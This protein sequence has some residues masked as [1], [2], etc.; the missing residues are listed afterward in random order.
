[1]NKLKLGFCM[2]GSFCTFKQNFELM[3]SLANE[4]DVLPIMSYNA[5][6]LDTRFGKAIDNIAKAE[7]I[8]RKPAIMTIEDAEPI[9]P[10]NLTDIL[11]V[12]PCTGNTMAK[13]A[14]SI[15]DTPVTMA[16]KSHLR[17]NRPVIIAI[18]TNDALAGTAKNLGKLLNFKNYYFVPF[19]QD[20][21]AKKPASLVAD[22]S[23]AGDT[24][25]AAL[26]GTQYQPII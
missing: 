1:M 26:L 9:G 21:Y 8:C 19:H 12:S 17:N 7:E 13:L 25:K 2:C 10:K 6:S 4:Y 11:L 18:S 15:V 3:E 20:N 16:V 14:N 24:I 23:L 22:F 5:C